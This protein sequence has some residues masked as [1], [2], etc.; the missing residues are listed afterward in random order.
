MVVKEH[1]RIIGR[2]V[3]TYSV[4]AK[5]L[6]RDV[7]PAFGDRTYT[8]T[9]AAVSELLVQERASIRARRGTACL[10][11]YVDEAQALWSVL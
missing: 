11:D 1:A 10:R 4:S 5:G 9:E 8:L 7:P 6:Y 2:R 3:E